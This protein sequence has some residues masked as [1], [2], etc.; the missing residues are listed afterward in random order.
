MFFDP[1]RIFFSQ[2]VMTAAGYELKTDEE[3]AYLQHGS[4]DPVPLRLR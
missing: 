2:Q 3:E 4:C 1:V